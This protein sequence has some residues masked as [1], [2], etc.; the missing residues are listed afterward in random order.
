MRLNTLTMTGCVENERVEAMAVSLEE[1]LS[2]AY[3]EGP[4]FFRLGDNCDTEYKEGSEKESEASNFRSSLEDTIDDLVYP[5]DFDEFKKAMAMVVHKWKT[6]NA[7]KDKTSTTAEGDTIAKTSGKSVSLFDQLQ[8]GFPMPVS[9][10]E[11]E[12]ASSS[13]QRLEV[14]QKIEYLEDL[15]MDWNKIGPVLVKD[16]SESFLS[17]PTFCLEL[18]DMHRKW[19]HKGRSSSEYTPLLFGICENLLQTLAKTKTIDEK[20]I[21]DTIENHQIIIVES[22]V[23]NWRDMWLDLM[24]RD[25]YSED[26]AEHMEQSMFELFL[27]PADCKVSLFAQEVLASVDSNATWFQSWTN[28]LPTNDHLV[29]L[30]TGD[31]KALLELWDKIRLSRYRGERNSMSLLH[32]TAIISI[33]LCRTRLSQFPWYALTNSNPPEDGKSGINNFRAVIDE[34]LEVF[35]HAVVFLS[36]DDRTDPDSTRSDLRLIF[37]DGIEAILAGSR[38]DTEAEAD[39]RRNKVRSSLQEENIATNSTVRHFLK[40]RL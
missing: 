25:Q 40:K 22:L 36:V 19:F 34:M 20:V 4:N 29:S 27:G 14:L 33:V 39:R 8:G 1:Q 37:L 5:S 24:Q 2:I 21:D 10:E 31:P 35:L 28:H 13:E 17:N 15:V 38:V 12:G 23:K 7:Q 3:P 16:L 11:I 32:P 18:I 6:K 9:F 26:L 30:L